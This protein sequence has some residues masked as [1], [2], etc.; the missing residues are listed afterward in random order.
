M[1]TSPCQLRDPEALT[2]R[3]S[4]A[5]AHER[6]L[7]RPGRRAPDRARSPARAGLRAADATRDGT[8]HAASIADHVRR[9]EPVRGC[10]HV[11]GW[12][13][14]ARGRY[15]VRERATCPRA[16]RHRA[17]AWR[18]RPHRRDDAV[19]R[20]RHAAR[21]DRRRAAPARTCPARDHPGSRFALPRRWIARWPR[22]P[23][24]PLRAPGHLRRRARALALG[25]VHARSP[26]CVR[27]HAA[28][29]APFTH[30]SRCRRPRRRGDAASHRRPR[31][32]PPRGRLARSQ[33]AW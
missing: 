18:R 12:M 30:L 31:S 19:L 3:R 29:S 26:R 33:R 15:A 2:V 7:R 13:A 24:R 9:S 21:H 14:R 28:T 17:R 5:A 25:V 1:R 4:Y 20:A 27:P 6:T 10:R 8:G 11:R 16:D 22:R 32:Q 23:V